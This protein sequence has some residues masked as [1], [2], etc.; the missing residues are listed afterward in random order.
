MLLRK[1]K[2]L[3]DEES[4]ANSWWVMVDNQ[5]LPKPVDLKTLQSR[6][7]DFG[8]KRVSILH[9]KHKTRTD[10]PWIKVDFPKKRKASAKKKTVESPPSKPSSTPSQPPKQDEAIALSLKQLAQLKAELE[11]RQKFIE[12]GERKLMTKAYEIEVKQAE[13]EQL[14]EDV[15]KKKS[16]TKPPFNDKNYRVISGGCT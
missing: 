9:S 16:K 13:L 8:D 12:Q 14:N 10:A 3:M 5:V 11:E 2:Q 15:E 4:L 6:R 7:E 1:L